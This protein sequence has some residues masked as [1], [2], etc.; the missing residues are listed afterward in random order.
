[1]KNHLSPRR[2]FVLFVL[3]IL[4]ISRSNSQPLLVE[5]FNYPAGSLLTAN[6]WIAHSGSG[7][8][9]VKV[10]TSGLSYTGYPSSNIGLSA[11]INNTGEDV[12]LTFNSVTTG[13]V[14]S[15][16]LVKVNAVDSGYFFHLGPKPVG[17]SHYGK[18]FICGSENSLRFGLSKGTKAPALTNGQPYATGT[19]YL[20]VLK[21]SIV[22]GTS[23][24]AVSLFIISGPIP[25]TEPSVPAIG[26]LTDANQ[27]D[28]SNISAVAL[29]QYSSKQDIIVDGIRV[30]TSWADAVST[31]TSLNEIPT[32]KKYVVYPSPATSEISIENCIGISDIEIFDLS[33]RKILTVKNNGDNNVKISVSQLIHGMYIIKLKSNEGDRYLKFIKS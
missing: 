4:L 20:I 24:D 16:F 1:M 2:L 7:T 12:N 8:N 19:N 14:F 15:A 5:N 30:A 31:S 13:T 6:G 11:I 25:A 3:A 26:P 27:P 32:D 9:P 21:Y 18:V 33:G 23:N 10:H 17:T 29:R 22:D 28:P